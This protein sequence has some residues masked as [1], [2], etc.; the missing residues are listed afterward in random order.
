MNHAAS[1]HQTAIFQRPDARGS[2]LG[3]AISL[4]VHALA[5]AWLW[6]AWSLHP[7]RTDVGPVKRVEVRLVPIAEAP[8]PVAPSN[9]TVSRHSPMQ[10][11]AEPRPTPPQHQAVASPVSPAPTTTAP[12]PSAD[13]ASVTGTASSTSTSPDAPAF[14]MAAARTS[15]RLIARQN[16]NGIVALPSRKPAVDLKADHHVAD[17]LER[18]RRVDCQTARAGSTNLLANVAMLAVDMAKNA[19]D[20]SGCKW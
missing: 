8:V 5:L 4:L 16:G 9:V 1:L 15:A 14:D 7:V 20:D 18:A 11:P 6:H 17:A 12:E 10:T 2:V 13:G 3:W 19:V